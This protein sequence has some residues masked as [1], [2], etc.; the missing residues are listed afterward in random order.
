MPDV[1]SVQYQ[2]KCTAVDNTG[3]E[4][5]RAD[6]GT[7]GTVQSTSATQPVTKRYT[8]SLRNIAGTT[9]TLDL[10]ALPDGQN[11]TGLKLQ[12]IQINTPST[13]NAAGMTFA[14]GASNGYAF[15]KH[16]SSAI[17][18]GPLDECMFKY[19]DS[20]GDVGSGAKTIDITCTAG[21]D[22]SV[23]FIFG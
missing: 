5:S 22:Y 23:N 2:F 14:K 9:E 7:S 11:M 8:H 17:T 20:L 15:L 13:N 3:P 19:T 21:D 1:T 18:L 10:A 16:A 4:T 6:I 12:F